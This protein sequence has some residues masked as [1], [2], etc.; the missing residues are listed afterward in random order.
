MKLF[1]ELRWLVVGQS[2]TNSQSKFVIQNKGL[3]REANIF[4][5]LLRKK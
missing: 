3:F 1:C 4:R 5:Q 2:F